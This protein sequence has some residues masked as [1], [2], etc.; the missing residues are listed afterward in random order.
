M[1]DVRRRDHA[2]ATLMTNSLDLRLKKVEEDLVQLSLYSSPPLAMSDVREVVDRA[3]SSIRDEVTRSM[4]AANVEM[5]ERFSSQVANLA[6]DIRQ[7]KQG[8]TAPSHV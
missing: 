2:M 7:L 6:N 1:G 4:R 5:E 8:A 3:V